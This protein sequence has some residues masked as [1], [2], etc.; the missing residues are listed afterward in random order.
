MIDG[1]NLQSGPYVASSRT[2]LDVYKLYDDFQ[3]AFLNSTVVL[4]GL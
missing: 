1:A 4:D 3:G 2:L